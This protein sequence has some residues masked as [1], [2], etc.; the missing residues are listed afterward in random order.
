MKQI[1]CKKKA[2]NVVKEKI[3]AIILINFSFFGTE[4][5]LAQSKNIAVDRFDEVLVSSHI[6]VTFKKGDKES[7]YIE[8]IDVPL[9]KL[10]IKVKQK[11]LSIYLEGEKMF[12][13]SGKEYKKYKKR[14]HPLYKGTVVKAVV[15]YKD[16]NK[17]SVK[18][19]ET[20]VFA[21]PVERN[22]FSLDIF[23]S[24]KVLLNET[25][26]NT[27]KASV[28][29]E[30]YLEVKKGSITNQDYTAYGESEINTLEVDNQTTD[31][32]AYGGGDFQLNVSKLITV[33]AYGKSRI[34]YKGNAKVNK[35]ILIGNTSI[36]KIN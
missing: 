36:Q 1:H 12:L 4:V 9:D 24:S 15:T 34:R 2:K 11:K 28:Y 29:G 33:S 5:V 22:K 13:E 17:L 19:D 14:K 3:L 20:F 16:L 8:E 21:S 26:L 30:G 27:M 18:G 35:Q 32:T 6:E 7:I 10:H 23:G 31:I 25:K